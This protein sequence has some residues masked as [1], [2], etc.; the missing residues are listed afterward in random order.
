MKSHPTTLVSL[1]CVAMAVYPHVM[2]NDNNLVVEAATITISTPEFL[3]NNREDGDVYLRKLTLPF[4]N[5][6]KEGATYRKND[7]N[8]NFVELQFCSKGVAGLY[9]DWMAC[10]PENKCDT[11]GLMVHGD[12]CG[13]DGECC[14]DNIVKSGKECEDGEFLFF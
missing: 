4:L 10:C 2:T 8:T 5:S 13:D 11:C 12:D 3:D 7:K 14:A 9:G 1:G 6:G